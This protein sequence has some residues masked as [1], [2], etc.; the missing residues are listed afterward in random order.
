MDILAYLTLNGE[1]R[2][3]HAVIFDNNFADAM[4]L[5]QS[6]FPDLYKQEEKYYVNLGDWIRRRSGAS[7]KGPSTFVRI[8][9]NSYFIAAVGMLVRLTISL[10]CLLAYSLHV[11][12]CSL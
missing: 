1:I 6:D 5:L 12:K 10:Y 3:E 7:K 4:R 11:N 9:Y 2:E 8:Q